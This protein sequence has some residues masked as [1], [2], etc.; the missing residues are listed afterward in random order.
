MFAI[1]RQQSILKLLSEN[2]KVTIT[3]L[4]TLFDTSHETIRK[5]LVHLERQNALRRIYGGA[6][7]VEAYCSLQPLAARK[8][9]RIDRKSELSRYA[10]RLIQEDD[11]IAIDEGSTAVEFAKVIAAR[12]SN[13]T[14]VTHNLEVFHILS[15]NSR[16][17]IILCGGKFVREENAFAGHFAA[18]VASQMHTRKAFICPAA[19]SLRYGVTDYGE[20]FI[21]IQKNYAANT[22]NVIVLAD[23]QKYEVSARYKICDMTP[24]ITLVTD[25]QLNDEIFNTY[26]KH[27]VDIIR[28]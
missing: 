26:K 13:L 25:S 16:F 5:D 23:S 27:N 1:E 28:G 20:E 3:E 22:D 6:V 17:S 12:F 9:E 11:I 15:E 18:E 19:V 24:D 7:S 4:V 14:V 21:P 2:G 10:A 8:A